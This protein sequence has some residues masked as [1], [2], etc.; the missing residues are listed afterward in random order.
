[1]Q[2]AKEIKAG[3]VLIPAEG[4]LRIKELQD[5]FRART[6]GGKVTKN[7]LAKVA[8]EKLTISDLLPA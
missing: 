3:N 2:D 8:L 7:T 1:M 6:N 5:E 4:M